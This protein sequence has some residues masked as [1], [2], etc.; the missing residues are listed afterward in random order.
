MGDRSGCGDRS[1]RRCKSHTFCCWS[2]GVWSC[3]PV[4][5]KE[6]GEYDSR[7]VFKGVAVQKDK[8]G[9]NLQLHYNTCKQFCIW[10][11]QMSTFNHKLIS[12]MCNNNNKNYIYIYTFP[13][14]HAV[15]FVWTLDRVVAVDLRGY[16]DTDKPSGIASYAVPKL[17]NDLKQVITALGKIGFIWLFIIKLVYLLSWSLSVCTLGK[18][19]KISVQ[20]MFPRHVGRLFLYIFCFKDESFNH[21]NLVHTLPSLAF[22]HLPPYSTITGCTIEEALFS[23]LHSN[24]IVSALRKV[25]VLIKTAES[26]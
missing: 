4:S 8:R 19:I 20:R 22:W 2:V 5:D 23:A 13:F 10:F 7:K 1:V 25:W 6:Q 18:H 16:G 24:I 21:C 17:V 15:T 11:V 12:Y 14:P 26:T 9:Q 3:I